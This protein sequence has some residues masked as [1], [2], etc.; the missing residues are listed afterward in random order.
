MSTRACGPSCG[1]AST[2]ISD[3]RISRDAEASIP[4]EDKNRINPPLGQLPVPLSYCWIGG[5]DGDRTR[6]LVNAIIL[7]SDLRHGVR[8]Q[9]AQSDAAPV[10]CRGCALGL[11]MWAPQARDLPLSIRSPRPP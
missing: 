7:V 2:A 5:A 9:R 10:R 4:N 8:S 1:N 3:S 6:D 11:G